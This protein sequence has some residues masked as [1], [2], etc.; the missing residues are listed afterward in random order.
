MGMAGTRFGRNIPLDKVL[1]VDPRRAVEPNPRVVSRRLLT[2]TRSCPRRAVNSLAAAWLQ[3]MIHDWFTHGMSDTSRLV[4][5]PLRAGDAWPERPDAD[6]A[7][8]RRPDPPAGAAGPVTHVNDFTHWWDGSSLYG[9]DAARS[10]SGCGPARTASCGSTDDGQPPIPDDP[11]LDPHDGA[12]VLARPRACCMTLFAREHNAD[13]RPAPAPTTRAGTTRSCSSAPGWSVAP[14]SRRS[15][16]SSGRRRSSAT[17]RR[18]SRCGPTGRG[19]Q[20]SGCTTFGRISAQRGHQ[21]HPRRRDRALRRPVLAHRGVHRRLPHAPADPRRLRPAD[22][23]RRRAAGAS[24]PSAS[25]PARTSTEI[26][27]D[28]T[29]CATC[30]TP[31]APRTPARSCCTTSRSSCRSSSGRTASCM[32][33]AATDILRI[34]ELGVPRYNEFRRLLHLK[35]R[36]VFDELTDDAGLGRGDGGS[37]RATSRR[38][39]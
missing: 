32:D 33:L 36:R 3:F 10:S 17:R 5:L 20:A 21:R 6:P 28:R 2:R 29:P 30:S 25:S 11:A 38:S 39:T 19:S 13:L 1:P 16:R 27:D 22:G 7:D 4:D 35:P 23:G 37:T 31:S 12:R 15:T 24:C 9:V 34:R 14:C 8:Q 26:M 18:S